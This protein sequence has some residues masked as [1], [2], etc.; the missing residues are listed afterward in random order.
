[1]IKEA[2]EHLKQA[3]RHLEQVKTIPDR[4]LHEKV[5]IARETVRKVEQHITER[6]SKESG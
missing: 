5:D 1:M 2:Q 3:Q 6:T 4:K